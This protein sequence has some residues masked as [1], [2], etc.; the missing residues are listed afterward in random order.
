LFRGPKRCS[1]SGVSLPFARS[2]LR[3][4]SSCRVQLDH[5]APVARAIRS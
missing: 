5:R 4:L 3:L 2:P 1:G